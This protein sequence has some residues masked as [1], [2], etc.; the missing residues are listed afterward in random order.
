M[1]VVVGRK[2]CLVVGSRGDCSIFCFDL[3]GLFFE[4]SVGDSE[5]VLRGEHGLELYFVVLKYPFGHDLAEASDD[6]GF[7][8]AM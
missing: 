2:R 4:F 8:L 5:V 1:F 6:V 3:D 7:F